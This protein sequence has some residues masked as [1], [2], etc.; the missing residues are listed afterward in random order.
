V[1]V[2]PLDT[3]GAAALERKTAA[4]RG[5]D[6]LARPPEG[7][8]MAGRAGAR[9]F[10]VVHHEFV[11]REAAD[12]GPQQRSRFHGGGGRPRAAITS[13]GA[14]ERPVAEGNS[15]QRGIEC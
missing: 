10:P 1:P 9:P 8:R 14:A 5:E 3:G 7:N 4:E 13:D 2:R 11:H 12:N 15:R 6:S